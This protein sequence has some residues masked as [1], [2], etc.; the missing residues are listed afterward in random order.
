MCALCVQT[1]WKLCF[2]TPT[3][4]GC[5]VAPA[6]TPPPPWF[7]PCAGQGYSVSS[8]FCAGGSPLCLCTRAG[9]AGRCMKGMPLFSPLVHTH[10]NRTVS[11]G[12]TSPL[13]CPLPPFMHEWGPSSTH[14]QGTGMQV[15]MAQPPPP[16]V[17][18]M[19]VSG[20][21]KW[22]HSSPLFCPSPSL[23]TR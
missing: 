10:S 17:L 4:P 9:N 6:C 20:A 16:S 19:H 8:P 12:R 18:L 3:P 14:Q 23:L 5:C 7:T 21:H 11:K 1:G 2:L 13:L 22:G 15:A